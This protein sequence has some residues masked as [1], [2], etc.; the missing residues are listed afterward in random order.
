MK[1]VQFKDKS[2]GIR[3]ISLDYLIIGHSIFKYARLYN[4]IDNVVIDESIKLRPDKL[5]TILDIEYFED[6]LWVSVNPNETFELCKSCKTFD[7][8]LITK[9]YIFLTKKRYK[10][11]LT[12]FDYGKAL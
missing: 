2:Y 4:I 12:K 5:K 3:K 10:N 8:E 1:I 9:Y 11:N 7:Y 6:T